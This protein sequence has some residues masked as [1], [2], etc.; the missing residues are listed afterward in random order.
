MFKTSSPFRINRYFITV[1][2]LY[3]FFILIGV[4]HS[5]AI[6]L[7]ASDGSVVKISR[8]SY[9]V[10]HITGSSESSLFFGQGF[11]VAQ[12]RLYQLEQFRRVG[13]G[14]I[15]EI[16]GSEYLDADKLMRTIFYTEDEREKHYESLPVTI[17]GMMQSYCDGINTYLDSMAVNP[18]RY[19]PYELADI[20]ID[21]W[22]VTNILAVQSYMMRR[23]GQF[24]GSELA[25]ALELQSYGRDWFEKHRPLNDYDAPATIPSTSANKTARISAVE[26]WESA[27]I[28]LDETKIN[29]L[30]TS[31][32]RIDNLLHGLG[33]PVK[34][35]SF[36]VII[37]SGK[38]ESGNVMLLGAPQ[39]EVTKEGQVSI[40][41]E[42]ELHCPTLH[43]GG[44]AVAG[45]PGILIGHNEDVAWTLTSGFSDNTDVYIETTFDNTFS[46]YLYN[47]EWIDFERIDE[48]II[49]SGEEISFT[50]Y[51]TI[52]GPVFYDDIENRQVFSAR[53]AFWNR[54]AE[55]LDA[56]YRMWKAGNLTEFEAG[57]STIPVSFNM[58]YA[59]DDQTIKLWHVGLYQDRSDGI[60]P[61]LPH[62]GGGDEEWG[63]IIPFEELPSVE[64]PIQGYLANWNNKPATWWKNG[65]NIPWAL[66]RNDEF[67]MSNPYY[68][69]T[70]RV[71][72]IE[73]YIAP[74]IQ[75]S[76]DNLKNVPK[77]I[78]SY[79][80]YM[81]AIEFDGQN[82]R[83]ENVLPPGQ[84]GFI[85]MN[86]V[87]SPHFNDQWPLN[88]NWEFKDME[89]GESAE[90]RHT[91][92][93]KK[94][95]I[96]TLSQNTPNP[97]NSSTVIPFT[98]EK[99]E[100]VHLVIYNVLG[101]RVATLIDANVRLGLHTVA[102][103]PGELPSGLYFYRLSA[104]SFRGTK[105]LMI[106]R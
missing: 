97:F 24:G 103:D 79:G 85:D 59:G 99:E 4:N 105:R 40:V 66:I 47:G 52:H 62:L 12:D 16:L 65:D 78:Q 34:F 29:N 55:T 53:I 88:Q 48:T 76:Y 6:E 63:G 91:D 30:T 81:Q 18:E 22:K 72:V 87:H 13:Y 17:R 31:R 25:R 90:K 98:L 73:Q 27:G 77:Q 89:F 23:F 84:S 83:D 9:G 70:D 74:I 10:P 93:A 69:Q 35:G 32:K 1:I 19:R 102:W 96:I 8:D 2:L 68:R 45:M 60:D 61:R 39:M 7:I 43:V 57:V 11:A 56:L 5:N 37:G 64:N 86:G 54:E 51:R 42:V 95:S 44:M 14:R 94:P 21:P 41:N 15:S 71:M 36:A 82:I 49:S 50:H 75:F 3:L 58:F 92:T 67:D 106:I 26:R 20:E 46:A 38:S 28:Q 101:E 104:G 80:T 100:H 33:I